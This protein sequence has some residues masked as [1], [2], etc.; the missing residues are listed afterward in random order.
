M[1]VERAK[2]VAAHIMKSGR[3]VKVHLYSF[4]TLALEVG[5]RAA[6]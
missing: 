2:I 5:E 4:L 1:A 3:R 6:L